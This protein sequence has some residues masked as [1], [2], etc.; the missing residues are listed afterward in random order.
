MSSLAFFARHNEELAIYKGVQ[1][2]A[3]VKLPP[4]FVSVWSH[5]GRCLANVQDAG[6][7][8]CDIEADPG[9]MKVRVMD[10]S[11]SLCRNMAWS[12]KSTWLLAH[13]PADK[14]KEKAAAEDN[15]LM[16]WD[17]STG[18]VKFSLRHPRVQ[19][20][21]WPVMK[22]TADEAMMVYSTA[23]GHVQLFDGGLSSTT[24][25]A[26]LP[27]SHVTCLEWAPMVFGSYRL[28]VFSAEGHNDDLSVSRP[29][30]AAVIEVGDFHDAKTARSAIQVSAL[31]ESVD[32]ELLRKTFSSVGVIAGCKIVVEKVGHAVGIIH[33][34]GADN[35]QEA[36]ADFN[37]KEIQGK[38][39][40][41]ETYNDPPGAQYWDEEIVFVMGQRAEEAELCWAPSARALVMFAQTEVDDTGQSYYGATNLYS[42]SKSAGVARIV[43]CTRGD[44]PGDDPVPLGPIIA[45]SWNPIHDEFVV[46][47]GQS[48]YLIT[49]WVWDERVQCARK[50]QTISPS[51]HRNTIRWNKFGSVVCIGGFGNLAGDVDFFARQSSESGVPTYCR[52]ASTKAACTVDVAWAPDGKHLIT[53]ILA[54]RMR[55]DNGFKIWNGLTGKEV[56]S[57]KV[58]NLYQVA[59]MPGGG[60]E[61]F[62]VDEIANQKGVA[63]STG[64]GKKQAYRPPRARLGGADVDRPSHPWDDAPSQPRKEITSRHNSDWPSRVDDRKWDKNGDVKGKGDEARKGENGVDGRSQE[65]GVYEKGFNKGGKGDFPSDKGKGWDTRAY[66]KAGVDGAWNDKGFYEKSQF[67]KGQFQKGQF[68]KGAFEKGGGSEK[69]GDK[70]RGVGDKGFD[71]GKSVNDKGNDKGKGGLE[72]VGEKGKGSSEKSG[73]GDKGSGKDGAAG[74]KGWG[75]GGEGTAHET[76]ELMAYYLHAKGIDKG[77]F[78]KGLVEK[79]VFDRQLPD[80][81]DGYGKGGSLDFGSGDKG[82]GKSGGEPNGKG[83]SKSSAQDGGPGSDEL[84]AVALSN[85]L[86]DLKPGMAQVRGSD[87]ASGKSGKGQL[88]SSTSPATRPEAPPQPPMPKMAEAAAPIVNPN[89]DKPVP[90]TGWQYVDPKGNTQGPFKLN[91][92]KHWFKL[93]YFRPDLKMRCSD[94]DDFAPFKQLYPR[95]QTQPFEVYPMRPPPR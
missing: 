26:T 6:V 83:K 30:N 59:W 88:A 49:L 29:A 91:E 57:E 31:H 86:N 50:T 46:I 34:E 24:P 63:A 13:R 44:G 66:D 69:G 64:A 33:F 19:R 90:T 76:G 95:P 94:E 42:L 65:K 1:G 28:A 84:V 20:A 82:K 11:S 16:V 32:G 2:E 79:G 47:S 78:Q 72:R 23:D 22:W 3:A 15:H 93:G 77:A 39:V 85:V 4:T 36:V 14:D 80:K 51:S 41:V 68:D 25:L 89:K 52:T 74:D 10:A 8:V 53:A 5:D 92:M 58:D 21:A 81:G 87:F 18:A 37:G 54:P 45:V 55:V 48:P 61:D 9:D 70:G 73:Y 71:K 60:G 67:E 12:E 38:A 7:L 40:L 62:T 17:P 35:A 27:L 56:R 75:K 43:E